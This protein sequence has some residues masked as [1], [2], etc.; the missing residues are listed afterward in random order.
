[1][2]LPAEVRHELS[3]LLWSMSVGSFSPADVERLEELA[4]Q[5]PEARTFYAQY[6]AMCGLLQWERRGANE[7]KR[8]IVIETLPAASP[9]PRQLGGWLFSYAAA[10]VVTGVMLL[11]FWAWKVPNQRE[12][13]TDAARPAPSAPERGKRLE[14]VGQITAWPNAA[15][16][17]RTRRRRPPSPWAASMSWFRDSWKCAYSTGARVILQ[18][19]C[20]Y[21]VESDHGGFLSLGKLTARVETKGD[22]GRGK[23]KETENPKSEIRN[24]KSA[25]PLSP[26]AFVVRTPAAIV[27]DLGTEFGVEARSDGVT[28]TEVFVGK[29]KVA[30]VA[31]NDSGG[32]EPRIV[33]AGQTVRGDSRGITAVATGPGNRPAAPNFIRAMPR[34]KSVSDAYAEMVLAMRPVVFYRMER[35]KEEKDRL[36]VFDSSPGRH[37]AELHWGTETGQPWLLGRYG[38]FGD[39]LYLGGR[40]FGDYAVAPRL[41]DSNTNQLSLS[42][43]AYADREATWARIAGE[44]GPRP[45]RFELG[46]Y[47]RDGD[48]CGV[49]CQADGVNA[50]VREGPSHPFPTGRWQHVALVADGTALHLYRNGVEVASGPCRGVYASPAGK[51]LTIGCGNQAPQGVHPICFWEGRLD[52]LAVF[53]RGS[54]GMR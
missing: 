44:T 11:V 12:L 36:V 31:G 23:G 29:V 53:H 8:P 14:Y 38:R 3:D 30:T 2:T 28:E 20:T 24:P 51:Y 17:V 5:Y 33:R 26:S 19:P 9:F 50:D 32:P 49:V 47:D 37:H 18:G 34:P 43:W 41:P 35:P 16:P 10:T 27:T 52:E 13:A 15:G 45:W 46:L 1:M 25:F 7:V 21:E 42:V 22:G 40:E 6:M 4:G 48:M 54:A 39:G